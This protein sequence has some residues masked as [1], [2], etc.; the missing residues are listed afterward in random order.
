MFIRP[1]DKKS[2]M[3]LLKTIS[4]GHALPEM[5]AAMLSDFGIIVFNDSGPIVFGWLYPTISSNLCIIENIIKNP[6]Y[7]LD[8]TDAINL[9]FEELHFI[10]KTLGYKF[11]RM[12]IENT[13][14]KNRVE[15]LGYMKT[16][17]NVTNYMGSL[18]CLG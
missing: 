9:L 3:A 2:D 13:S 8:V 15:K 11:I 7:K 1:F 14:M 17:E 5:Q 18:L 4:D 16:E 10:A 6:N 12:S